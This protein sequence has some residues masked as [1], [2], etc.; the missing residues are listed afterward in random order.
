[1]RRH[2]RSLAT[3]LHL[4][5]SLV[6]LVW[7]CLPTSARAQTPSPLQEWQYSSGIMLE[8]LFEPTVPDWRVVL[9]AAAAYKPLYDGAMLYR[10]QGGPVINVRYRDLAFAS[11]SEG[12]GF[13]LLV[14]DKYRAGVAHAY[15]LGRR[16]SD[17]YTHLRGLGDI[18]RAPAI[19]AFASYVI[20]KQ[21]PLVM[22]TDVRQMIGGADGL[23]GDVGIYMPLPGSSKKLVM[24][25]GPSI[26]FAD[27]LYEQKV[28]GVSSAQALASRYSNYQAHAGMNV[29]GMGFSATR[30]IT[31]HWLINVDGAYDRLLGSAA[32]SPI[33][34]RKSQRVFALSVDY[35]W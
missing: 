1:M 29:A 18:S 3:A 10:T 34:Q 11:V 16:V 33:T 32:D 31:E 35:T 2:P 27:R 5:G 15:D 23:Q 6:L 25:A 22:R 28:F 13:N 19:K 20:S 7:A 4:L 24:F 26:T 17:D 21:F 12:L 30:F 9:G 14:G 8:K